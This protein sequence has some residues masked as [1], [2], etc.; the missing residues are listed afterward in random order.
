MTDADNRALIERYYGLVDRGELDQML[1]LFTED[2]IYE[3]PGT[4]PLRGKADLAAFYRGREVSVRFADVFELRDRL[5]S[6]RRS[7][8]FVPAI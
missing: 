6:R 1:E 3:P 5:V 7:Y 2:C 4:A 8:F